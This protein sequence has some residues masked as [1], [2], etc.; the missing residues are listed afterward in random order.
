VFFATLLAGGT[1]VSAT[2]LPWK[3]AG[4]LAIGAAVSSLVLTAVQY[5]GNLGRDRAT[6]LG[7]WQDTVVRLAKT[8]LA[9]LGASFAADVFNVFTFDWTTALNVAVVATIGALGKGLL[10]REP[11][12]AT[13]GPSPSTLPTATY[14]TA[15]EASTQVTPAG[16]P[17]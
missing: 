7:F 5:L 12:S 11:K 1:A 4:T 2:G 8:F 3:Y 17:A 6:N 10:A 9:S 16:A 15:V 14:A 13:R